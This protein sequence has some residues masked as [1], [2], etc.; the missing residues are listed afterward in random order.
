MS[1][2]ITTITGLQNLPNL[3]DFNADW[4]GLQTVDLSGLTSLTY[5][6]VSDCEI[7]GVGTN[8]L[9]SVNV[10]GC[11][12]L[13]DFRVD[14]SDFSAN[15]ISSIIGLSDLT[16]LNTLDVDGCEL[17]GTI[18]MSG[19]PALDFLDLNDNGNLTEVI[20]TGSQ[21]INDFN[22]TNCN[23]SQAVVDNILVALSENGTSSGEVD[24]NGDGMGIPSLE[25]GVPAIRTLSA[26]GWSIYLNNYSSQFNV[27]DTYATEGEVCAASTFGNAI[28]TYTDT[29][30][31]VGNYGY[32]DNL[33]VA[34]YAE[35]WIK[36]QDGGNIY[37]V[38]GSGLI[39]SQ[40]VCT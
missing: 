8:S 20:I 6:D 25:T 18:D 17:S 39:V 38:S 1:A 2:V 12:A 36:T 34:P 14:D 16:S 30:V 33:L 4:N 31:E 29:D 10:T 5:V 19:F 15:S 27:T 22:G 11:T 23:F 9:T 32:A 13:T 26:N 21:P 37:L 24:M 28:Y 40:S 7:P 35:G 3:Q